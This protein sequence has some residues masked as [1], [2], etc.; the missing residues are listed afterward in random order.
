MRECVRACA[1]ER[2]RVWQVKTLPTNMAVG[3]VQCKLWNK[4]KI[5]A[6]SCVCVAF[7]EIGGWGGGLFCGCVG[8]GYVGW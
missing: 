4:Q 6:V 3:L 2:E 8:D 1:C 5:V 7:G